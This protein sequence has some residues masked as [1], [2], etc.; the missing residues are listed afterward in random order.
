ME[1]IEKFNNQLAYG[2]K[3][4]AGLCTIVALISL[5]IIYGGNG[6]D[7]MRPVADANDKRATEIQ[8]ELEEINIE[9]TL[10]NNRI[11]VDTAKWSE[12]VA[13]LATKN[14]LPQEIAYAW[15]TELLNRESADRNLHETEYKRALEN[16]FASI[17]KGMESIVDAQ[18][19]ITLPEEDEDQENAPAVAASVLLK[20][21]P[22]TRLNEGS[23]ETM[24]TLLPQGIEGLKLE[25][26]A[27]IDSRGRHYNT[28]HKDN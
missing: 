3:I 9:T 14:L 5:I 16:S 26:L 11:M 25:D 15:N 12:A 8:N 24:L 19:T 18:V 6:D 20:L 1:N 23:L 10:E 22:K 28:A 27:I 4:T 7:K 2:K 21:A 17:I 13:T